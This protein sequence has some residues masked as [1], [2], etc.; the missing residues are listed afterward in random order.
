MFCILTYGEN[1]RIRYGLLGSGACALGFL[2][3]ITISF[4]TT[5]TSQAMHEAMS[6]TLV[7]HDN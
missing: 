4:I 5:S 6:G 1:D 3:C 7:E 2:G